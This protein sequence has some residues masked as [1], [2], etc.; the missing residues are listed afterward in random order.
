[1]IE[2]GFKSQISIHS[3]T[4]ASTTSNTSNDIVLRHHWNV[5]ATPAATPAITSDRTS[6]DAYLRARPPSQQRPPHSRDDN[7]TSD[8]RERLFS[9]PVTGSVRSLSAFPAPPTR[10]PLPPPRPR[11]PPIQLWMASTHVNTSPINTFHPYQT[12]T[13]PMR[14]P[15]QFRQHPHVSLPFMMNVTFLLATEM[16]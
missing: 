14:F 6:S 11:D 5:N 16:I 7:P 4:F 12:L 15:L 3:T 2:F 1:M 13:H 9:D 10:F 8:D